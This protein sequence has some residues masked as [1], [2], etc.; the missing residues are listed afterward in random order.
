MQMETKQGFL[1]PRTGRKVARAVARGM[2]LIEIMIVV[3]IIA[4]VAGGVAVVAIPKMREAQVQQAETGARVI[5]SAVSQWQLAENEYG[6]CPTVSQLV[7]DKQL[8]AGQNTT[9][10]WGEEYTITCA[11]DE[12]IVS[13]TGPDKRKGTGDDI[14]IP[15]GAAVEEQES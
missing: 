7:E 14:I 3:A 1:D 5:R 10:P 4:M 8:D 9:D 11:D 13:S 12:V 15:K 6:E 2:T